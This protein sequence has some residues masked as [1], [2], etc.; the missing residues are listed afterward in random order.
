M[1]TLGNVTLV[2]PELDKRVINIII[3]GYPCYIFHNA[4]SKASDT[5]NNITGFDIS[6][7]CVDLYY[8]FDKSS[9]RKCA[10]KE[11]YYFVT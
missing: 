3:P 8:W 9:K 2:S 5:F 1:P 4:S 7:H 6:D 10:L 11:Y